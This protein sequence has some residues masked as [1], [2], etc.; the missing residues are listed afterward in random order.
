M[1]L[2]KNITVENGLTL[3]YH[4]I[5]TIL[6]HTNNQI[7]IEVASY[8]NSQERLK[9]KQLLAN[10]ENLNNIRMNIY[11]DTKYYNLSYDENFSV[12]QAY[13]YLKTLDEFNSSEDI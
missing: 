9:E 5:N 11:I 8:L 2:Q 13:N 3:S 4:R 1:A 6:I 10:K 7:I 12:K